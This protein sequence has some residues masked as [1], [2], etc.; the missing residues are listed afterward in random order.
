MFTS[1]SHP[2]Q[3]TSHSVYGFINVRTNRHVICDVNEARN[4]EVEFFFDTPDRLG[5]VTLTGHD[6][7]PDADS[8]QCV[9]LQ[10]VTHDTDFITKIHRLV[11][12]AKILC[13]AIPQSVK[14]AMTD[15]AIVV[16]HPHGTAKALSV[17][18]LLEYQK[19]SNKSSG[20]KWL[21]KKRFKLRVTT[22]I[23]ATCPG[24]TGAPI[25][26]GY[27]DSIEW[28]SMAHSTADL[29]TGVQM[30]FTFN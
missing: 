24:C 16:S 27:D 20:F 25:V 28:W 1:H 23:T 11:E 14:Y 10:C 18:G 2:P 3:G 13:A 4:T 12:D 5:I 30:A 29:A 17:G 9:T 26:T 6:V 21:M 8:E 19:I 22:Y 7:I 15:F